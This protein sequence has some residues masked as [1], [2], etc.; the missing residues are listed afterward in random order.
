MKKVEYAFRNIFIIYLN[1]KEGES[2]VCIW[3]RLKWPGPGKVLHIL[4][5]SSTWVTYTGRAIGN[6]SG[7]RHRHRRS[8]GRRSERR[9]CKYRSSNKL[10][11]HHNF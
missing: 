3:R 6:S 10:Q 7:T 1:E 8:G 5:I 11:G 4:S 2:L 9:K